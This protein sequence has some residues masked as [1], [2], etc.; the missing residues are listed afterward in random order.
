MCGSGDGKGGGTEGSFKS[1]RD[2]AVTGGTRG[3]AGKVWKGEKG[4]RNQKIQPTCWAD[5]VRLHQTNT[6]FKPGICASG[7]QVCP[8]RRMS[9]KMRRS[10][11]VCWGSLLPSPGWESSRQGC[12]GCPP[13][14]SGPSAALAFLFQVPCPVPKIILDDIKL[15][16]SSLHLPHCVRSWSLVVH[17][18]FE[19]SLP[20]ATG[21]KLKPKR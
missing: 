7:A 8:R 6:P 16:G 2:V 17:H 21:Q 10:C 15:P 5:L 14:L 18:C 13:T 1:A 11:S 20:T 19:A 3:L 12:R 4:I 9:G